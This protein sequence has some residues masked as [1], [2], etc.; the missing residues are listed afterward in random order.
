MLRLF[1]IQAVH[2][3]RITGRTSRGRSVTRQGG[4]QESVKKA[5]SRSGAIG[6]RNGVGCRVKPKPI[7]GGR[8]LIV[9]EGHLFAKV[10]DVA[11]LVSRIE[12]RACS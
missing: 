9:G 4:G 2:F 12:V 7:A 1:W 11:V 6:V 3:V 10:L 8:H 5:F